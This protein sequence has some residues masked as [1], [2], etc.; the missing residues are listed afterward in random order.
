M[1]EPHRSDPGQLA[2]ARAAV[3]LREEFDDWAVLYDPDSAVAV[4]INPVGV[5]I[6]RLLDGAHSVQQISAALRAAFDDVPAAAPAQVTA[7]IAELVRRGLAGY[8]VAGA[9]R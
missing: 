5:A 2:V 7:F 4:G 9:G 6:W 3:V 1:N 8:E